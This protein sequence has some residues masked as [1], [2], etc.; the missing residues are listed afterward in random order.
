MTAHASATCDTTRIARKTLMVRPLR[1]AVIGR[2][3]RTSFVNEKSQ[4]H[5]CSRDRAEAER[6]VDFQPFAT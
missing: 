2:R 6:S 4:R 5:N 1:P 3:F